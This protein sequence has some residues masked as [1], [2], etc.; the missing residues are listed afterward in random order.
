MSSVFPVRSGHTM[1][2]HI[3]PQIPDDLRPYLDTIADRLLSGHAA[4][5]IGAGFSKNAVPLRSRPEFPDWFQL[6]NCFY[7]RLH[8]RKPEPDRNYLQVPALAHEIE[9]AFGRPALNKM[10]RDAIPDL[11]HEPSPLHV[12]LLDL[13]WSDVFTTNYDTLLER[14]CRSIISQRYNVV[15]NPEDLGHSK[16]PRIVKLHG[17]LPSDRPFT[18]TDEDYRRYP[19]DSAPFVNAVRQALLENTLCLIGFSG[20]DPNFLQWIGWIRDNLGDE[21]SPKMYV[22]G[23]LQLSHSQKMLLERRNIISVDMSQC[24]S[25]DG[26]HY[27]ALEQF[28]EYLRLRRTDDNRLDWPSTGNDETTPNDK[29]DPA[30]LVQVWKSQRCRYPGWVILPEDRRLTLWLETRRWTSKVPAKDALPGVLDIEFTFE[31]TWRMEKCLSPL[32]DNQADFLEATLNRYW[33][34]RNSR[35]QPESPPLNAEDLIARDLTLEE[36][37]YMC[38]YLILTM[39]RHYREEGLGEKWAAMCRLIQEV[40]TTL[41][42]EHAARLHHE[43]ALFALFSL[44]LQ[45]LKTRLAEWPRNDALPFW[46]AKKAGRLAEIGEVDEAQR[47]LEHSLEIIRTK[48]NLTPTQTDYALVSQESFVMFMLHAV[49]QRSLFTSNDPSDTRRQRREFQE[50]WHA[51]RQYKCDPWQ[52]VEVFAHK[53]D[54]PAVTSSDVTEIPAFDIGMIVRTHHFGNPNEEALTAYNFLRFCEDAGI[55]FRIPGCTIATES[56]SGTLTRITAYSSYWAL[57]TL[58]RI[59]NTKV[60]DKIFD[61]ASLARMDAASVDGLVERYM[62]SVRRAVSDIRA[63]DRFHDNNFGMLLAGVVPE[64]LSRLCCKRSRAAKN[65]LLESL[66]IGAPRPIPG[67]QEVTGRLLRR[68][69]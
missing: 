44:N 29:D 65:T 57:V 13:P 46:A 21:N 33:P 67:N 15:V 32:F 25:V 63:G 56:A 7:E 51:L 58:V 40:E 37:R 1:S 55:P 27:R 59:G 11:Q 31:L 26:D 19:H 24:P 5:M 6:G 60:V 49:R 3:T 23:L 16:R 9:A 61:R 12:K 39:M 68:S 48:L 8:G 28:L 22:V 18:V 64:I 52:E 54:R 34:V 36:V 53:L 66:S 20:D 38:H 4:V 62:E 45:G 47:I 42:Q 69:R 14:A 2:E 30:K 10:L 43:R 35:T 17:S 41:S 50:R